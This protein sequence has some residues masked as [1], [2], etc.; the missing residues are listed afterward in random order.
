M[1]NM[2]VLSLLLRK[3]WPRLKFLSTHT[4]RRGCRHQGYDISSPDIRS[5]SLKIPTFSRCVAK[6]KVKVTRS[7]IMVKRE[8]SCNMAHIQDVKFE[9]RLYSFSTAKYM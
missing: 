5:G 6:L 8:R 7:N 4:R 3:L 2:K 1:C 9:S